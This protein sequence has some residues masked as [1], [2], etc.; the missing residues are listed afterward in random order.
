MPGKGEEGSE[1]EKELLIEPIA[2]SKACGH[3]NAITVPGGSASI[4]TACGGPPSVLYTSCDPTDVYFSANQSLATLPTLSSTTPSPVVNC[5]VVIKIFSATEK[6]RT[7]HLPPPTVVVTVPA[8]ATLPVPTF[9]FNT[10]QTPSLLR[11]PNVTRIVAE[12]FPSLPTAA[13]CSF[14]YTISAIVCKDCQART[15]ERAQELE[16]KHCA[17]K[18]EKSKNKQRE[19]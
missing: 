19:H 17:K 15:R 9:F 2:T 11:F 14:S 1:N 16:R 7:L 10:P 5:D 18:R 6:T 12:C 4:T 8:S 13:V 3:A